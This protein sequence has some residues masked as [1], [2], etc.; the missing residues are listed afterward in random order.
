MILPEDGDVEI[1]AW[2]NVRR[3]D[4]MAEENE[5][6]QEIVNVWSMNWQKYKRQIHLAKG[7]TPNLKLKWK[8]ELQIQTLAN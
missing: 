2:S 1:I 3:F 6:E 4:V 7:K 8:I 5:S